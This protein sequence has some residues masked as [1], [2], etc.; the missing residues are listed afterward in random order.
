MSS[1]HLIARA[2]NCEARNEVRASRDATI[3]L[4]GFSDAWE[5][6]LTPRLLTGQVPLIDW[7]EFPNTTTTASVDQGTAF[8]KA[9]HSRDELLIHFIP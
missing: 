5:S 3:L 6:P 9:L 4:V 1:S 8:A 2:L 7:L